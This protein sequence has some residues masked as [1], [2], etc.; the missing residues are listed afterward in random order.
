MQA[1]VVGFQFLL[2]V[3]GGYFGAGAG[4]LMLTSLGFLGIG[5]IHQM[6]GIKTIL[7]AT[8]NSVALVIF[9]ANGKIVWSY[10]APMA[11]A[12]ILGGYYGAVV[13]RRLPRRPIRSFVISIGLSLSTY[14]F[15]V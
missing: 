8:I 7:I 6:N 14:Y 10:A 11:A 9:I 2:S 5:T 15:L 12:S 4:I 3:Y 13:G 1:A